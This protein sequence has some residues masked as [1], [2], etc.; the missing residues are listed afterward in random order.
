MFEYIW[1]THHPVDDGKQIQYALPVPTLPVERTHKAELGL[2]A[3]LRVAFGLTG[4]QMRDGNEGKGID[5]RF[6]WLD[7]VRIV[8]EF[9]DRKFQYMTAAEDLEAIAVGS[10]SCVLVGQYGETG[11]GAGI[12]VEKPVVV[13]EHA[14]GEVAIALPLDFDVNVDPTLFATLEGDLHESVSKPF[15]KFGVAHDLTQLGVFEFM[16]L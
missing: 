12:T 3:G 4:A 15:A 2:I 8:D 9:D 7:A 11:D 6:K 16:A 1:Q 14:P 10:P 13:S 5:A